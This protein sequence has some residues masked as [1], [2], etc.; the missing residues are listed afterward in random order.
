MCE[1]CTLLYKQALSPQQSST[2]VEAHTGALSQGQE[3]CHSVPTRTMPGLALRWDVGFISG[4]LSSLVNLADCLT[5]YMSSLLMDL[6][7]RLLRYPYVVVTG[8]MG[9]PQ[10]RERGREEGGRGNGGAQL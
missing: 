1:I 9:L 6:S 7:V 10:E 2:L 5:R 3:P 8:S 4:H